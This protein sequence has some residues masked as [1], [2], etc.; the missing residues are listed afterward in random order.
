MKCDY[1]GKSIDPEWDRDCILVNGDGD[2]V[3]SK[4]CFDK[5]EKEKNDFLEN[6]LPDDRKFA[7]WLGVPLQWIQP[8]A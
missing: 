4:N 8:R 5:R 1:C 2:F 6:I 3:C 7:E